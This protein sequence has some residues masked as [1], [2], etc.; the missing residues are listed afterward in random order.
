[1]L[2][3]LLVL[4]CCLVLAACVFMKHPKF[5]K[6]PEGTRLESIRKSPNYVD[7][8]FRNLIDTPKF[9]QDASTF[10]I[11]LNHMLHPPERLTPEQP[12]PSVKTDLK[13]L[14]SSS[15][16]VIWLGH[17]SYYFQLGGKR[18]LLDP[19]LSDHAAPL[20]FLNKAFAG[21]S[22]Y[23]VDDIPE[24][25]YLLISH[26]HWDHLDYP[27]VEAL[28]DKIKQVVCPLGVGTYFDRWGFDASKVSEGDW[29][30]QFEYGDG[31][32][33]H[34]LPARH[35]SNRL[36]QENQTL[37][38]GF[39]LETDARRLF[40]S[41]DSGYGPH[42]AEIGRTFGGFDFAALDCGQYD[43]RWA[44]I[45]MNP[46]EA[47]QAAKDLNAATLLPSHVGRFTIA[48]HAW[49][50]P[51][52]RVASANNGGNSRLLTPAI[53]ETVPLENKPQEFSC[54]WEGIDCLGSGS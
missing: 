44:N 15:D 9:T 3:G 20:S 33:I 2:I 47:V 30:D 51:F 8:E 4:A 43:E 37:W 6:A 14:D 23:T 40:F 19:I 54:W 25:D 49:D 28:K 12:V 35:Y 7:G 22:I 39:A 36:L 50:E 38:A 34:L 10:S 42:F 46:E 5:G 11:L 52:I 1:M 13:A 32:K 48:R 45:H 26:E 17:S 29:Y 53:G 18:F 24:I 27:T 41:G 21:T 31:I 16:L